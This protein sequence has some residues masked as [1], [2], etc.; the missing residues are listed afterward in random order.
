M[1]DGTGMH[2]SGS[3]SELVSGTVVVLDG[4]PSEWCRDLPKGDKH[5]LLGNIGGSNRGGGV[6]DG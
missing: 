5:C 3:S 6:V 1:G 4:G 2:K